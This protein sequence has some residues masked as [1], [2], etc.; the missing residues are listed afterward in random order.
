M[1]SWGMVL[2]FSCL[3]N[4]RLGIITAFIIEAFIIEAYIIIAF[5]AS[6]HIKLDLVSSS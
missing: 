1:N 6:L 5:I 4:H 2:V 3:S